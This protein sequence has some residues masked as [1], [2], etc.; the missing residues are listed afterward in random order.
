VRLE[1]DKW[2]P[3]HKGKRRLKVVGFDEPC[4]IV[5]ADG[6]DGVNRYRYAIVDDGEEDEEMTLWFCQ[7]LKDGR[8]RRRNLEREPMHTICAGGVGDAWAGEYWLED[9]GGRRVVPTE[10]KPIYR[11]P[12][13]EEVRAIPWNGL[14][15]ASTFSGC[16]GSCLGYRMAGYRV[17]W[18]NEFVP[19]AQASYKANAAPDSFLDC[20][21]IAQVRA[22]EILEQI[23]MEKGELDLFDGSP[24]CQAFSTA[25]KREK[26]WGEN[27]RYE[28][29][30]A[31][32]NETLFDQYIRLLRGLMPRAFVAENVSGLVKGVAKGMFLEILADLKAAGYRVTAKLLDAKWLGVPQ[33]RQRVI[34]VGVREDLGLEPAHPK[35]FPYFYTLRDALPWIRSYV[36]DTGDN[37]P[38]TENSGDEPVQTIS[39][40]KNAGHFRVEDGRGLDSYG[41][42]GVVDT[43][44]PAPCV[45]AGRPWNAL[46]ID[47]DARID[48][49]AIGKEWDRLNPGQQ[50]DRFFSL[51]R[52]DADAPSPCI[53]ASHGNPGTAGVTH[54]QERRKFTIAELKR[55]CAFPDDFE[56]VG[57]YAQQWERLGNS[58]PPLMMR[59]VAEA[60]RDE[61]LLPS[62]ARPV[63]SRRRRT[64]RSR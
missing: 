48:G 9:D 63:D 26:G 28:G 20:R 14:T 38:V 32:Q 50:S 40:K 55:I 13:M 27:K 12:S 62:A 54:P 47:D 18:A 15:V 2:D 60:I 41:S 51:V 35:P 61:V 42:N 16:G 53:Q 8:V 33:S 7:R 19:S 57:T 30:H 4:P 36:R 3:R 17:A 56:L 49:F 43:E 21:D 44:A 24:P 22:E 37:C 58:V 11:V 5:L 6:L 29:G 34:F 46:P 31:Q 23:G 39:G 52:P 59:A 64:R 25:G 10:S 45:R 1:L